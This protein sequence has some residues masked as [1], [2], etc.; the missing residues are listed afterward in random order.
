MLELY[1]SFHRYYKLPNIIKNFITESYYCEVLIKSQYFFI[2]VFYFIVVVL[3][4]YFSF[5]FYSYI[6]MCSSRAHVV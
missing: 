6:Y 4:L 3:V 2:V 5:Y 1:F